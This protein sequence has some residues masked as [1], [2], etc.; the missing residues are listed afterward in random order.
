[1]EQRPSFRGSPWHSILESLLGQLDRDPTLRAV[2]EL[3]CEQVQ[4]DRATVFVL[5]PARRTLSGV[6]ALGAEGHP[7]EIPLDF[8]SIAGFAA[9][10]DRSVRVDDVGA[11]LASI[12]ARLKF[13]GRIDELVGYD[14]RSVLATPIR[15]R[16]AVI[17]VMEALSGAPGRFAPD[18]VDRL[19]DLA[20]VAGLVLHVSR[21]YQDIKNLR[22]VERRK[23]DF[24]DLLAHE[25][26]EPIAAV[27]MLADYANTVEN[28]PVERK[29]LLERIVLR[30]QQVTSLVNELLEV[31]RVKRGLVLGEV[32]PVDLVA[33]ATAT[34]QSME[35]LAERRGVKVTLELAPDAPRARLDDGLAPY[36]FTNLVSNALKYTDGGGTARLLVH[37]DGGGVMIE[38]IDT[39]IG[40]PPGELRRLFTEF[41]RATNARSR[42]VDGTGLG[43]VAVKEIA[44][45]FGG[46]VGVDST[47]GQGSRF[48]VWLPALPS[49]REPGIPPAADGTAGA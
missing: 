27:H 6:V 37:G 17:G 34:V 31:S 48:W 23:S 36:L 8:D 20:A 4:A 30:T 19:E 18:D 41:Y 47:L 44:E 49:E 11:D 1:M 24:I 22:E 39:G 15:E 38:A 26:K 13:C 7:L 32:R 46:R 42:G 12:D 5:D 16:G 28:D 43:L 2:A 14:T 33:L 35:D 29:R 40:V 10:A 9:L 21:L 45:R 25:I 3:A